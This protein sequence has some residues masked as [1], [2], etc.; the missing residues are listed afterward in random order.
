MMQVRFDG[1]AVALLWVSIGSNLSA[2]EPR[3]AAAAPEHPKLVGM[4]VDLTYATGETIAGV[5]ILK[6]S[7]GRL[8]EGSITSV[9][10]ADS[11]TGK[12]RLLG[13]IQ[14]REIAPPGGRALLV[15]SPAYKALVSPDQLIKKDAKRAEAKTSAAKTNSAAKPSEAHDSEY[16]AAMDRKGVHLW[17]ELTDREQ[18]EM[19]EQQRALLKEAGSKV[20]SQG[21]KLYE[22]KRFLFY[23]DIPAQMV[24]T[25]YV[26]YL[27]QMY[28]KLC[29][30]YGL[31][32]NTNIFKGKAVIVAYV[33]HESFAAFEEAM[34]HEPTPPT[35]QGL[36]HLN[37]NGDVLIS[38]YL[39]Q[40]PSYF[41]AVL[42]HETAH[43]FTHRFKSSEYVP[44]WLNEGI[45][46]WVANMVVSQD[47]GI[48]NK[49]KLAVQEMQ[50]THSMGGNFFTVERIADWQYGIAASMVDFLVKYTPPT[51]ARGKGLAKGRRAKTQETACFRKLV[52]GIKEGTPWNQSLQD[53]YGLTPN[54]LVERYGQYMGIA[55]LQP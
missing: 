48:R 6:A 47:D 39:G 36:A 32:T 8:I 31:D 30:V 1:I 20:S 54:E 46:E 16:R 15:Y 12:P 55:N 50:T 9:T 13:A 43:G 45:S 10:I 42:V 7:P 24:T 40:R 49:V 53:A 52:D 44:S 2:A 21:M 11:D 35:A 22:T 25:L 14:I 5:K 41:A 3:E 23:S 4:V 34:F 26:P 51:A 33:S 28:T 37:G 17:P 18:Q 19:V 29:W 27:D 38:C